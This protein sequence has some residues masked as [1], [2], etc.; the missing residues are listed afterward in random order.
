MIFQYLEV[1]MT[2]ILETLYK[3]LKICKSTNLV[4]NREKYHFMVTER[5]V[6]GHIVLSKGLEVDRAKVEVIDKLPL[7]T[8]VKGVRSF[9]GHAGFYRWF[10]KDFSKILKSLRNL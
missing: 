3:V 9:L 7:P 8:N 10:I 6:P 4:L 2:S 5:I 1:P